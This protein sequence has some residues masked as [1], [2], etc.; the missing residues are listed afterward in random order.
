MF[1]EIIMT[2]IKRTKSVKRVVARVFVTEI[3]LPLNII[4]GFNEADI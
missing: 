2:R 4:S 3:P 1:L